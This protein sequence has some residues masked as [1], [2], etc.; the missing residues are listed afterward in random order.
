[1]LIGEIPTSAEEIGDINCEIKPLLSV[2]EPP[3][4]LMLAVHDPLN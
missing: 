1:M 3:F 4:D 2:S